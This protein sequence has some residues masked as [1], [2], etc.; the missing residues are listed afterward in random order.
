MDICQR[1]GDVAPQWVSDPKRF[2]ISSSPGDPGTAL[3]CGA[4]QLVW[5]L[6][7]GLSHPATGSHDCGLLA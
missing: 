1:K 7:A 4:A 3:A 5:F 6:S 2:A